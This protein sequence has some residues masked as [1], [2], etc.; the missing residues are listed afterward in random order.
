[1]YTSTMNIFVWTGILFGILV[2]IPTGPVAFLIIQRMYTNG[3]K[4]AR[5]Q[6]PVNYC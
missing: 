1:M 5:F 4:L 2:A 6:L 3:L